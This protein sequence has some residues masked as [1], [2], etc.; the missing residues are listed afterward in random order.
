MVKGCGIF[1]WHFKA[2]KR[3]KYWDIKKINNIVLRQHKSLKVTTSSLWNANMKIKVIYL[4]L[5]KLF[6]AVTQIVQFS[7]YSENNRLMRTEF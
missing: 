4:E 6:K 2:Y 5:R 3:I 7:C 1:S